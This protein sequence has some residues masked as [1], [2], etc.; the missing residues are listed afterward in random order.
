[1]DEINKE[2]DI[3]FTPKVK[4]DKKKVIGGLL[5]GA[6]PLLFIVYLVL[7]PVLHILSKDLSAKE[8]YVISEFVNVRATSDVN[9]LKM[10]KAEYGTKLL[11]YEIKDDF[12]E[13][14]IDGQKGFVSSEFIADPMT[15]YAIEGL[16]GDDKAENIFTNTK[17]KLGLLRYLE[18]KGYMSNIPED[19]QIQH[20]GEKSKKEVYQIFTEPKGSK[21]NASV[22][23]DLDGDHQVEAAFVL[24]NVN[25]DKKILVI[26][27]FDKKDPLKVSKTLFEKE[28]DKPWY[29]IKLAKKGTKYQM[30]DKGKK[31]GK[32][33]IP[34]NGLILG[35]NR[36]KDLNDPESLVIYNGDKFEVYE[37][38]E[39]EK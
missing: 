21:F 34:V 2:I 19:I 9:S 7:G 3:E 24:K 30:D 14:L 17:Y 20:S 27:W 5:L 39:I 23:S 26:L 10:G 37:Q 28:I 25:S 4:R 22:L 18:S 11:V 35:S 6:I 12:A 15:Y 8:M 36:M 1:M 38:T 33:K 29:F 16:F 32:V 31:S 13:V